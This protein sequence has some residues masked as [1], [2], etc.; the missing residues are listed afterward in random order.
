[1][2]KSNPEL[3]RLAR[4]A[5][6]SL[7][8]WT[9]VVGYSLYSTI[10]TER[11]GAM[12][13]A[14]NAARDNFFKDQAFRLWAS[15]KGG[16]YVVVDERNRPLPYM[17]HVPGRDIQTADGRQL[18]LMNPASMLR[19][20][21][22]QYADLY[23]IK[24]RIVGIKTLN[25]ANKADPWEEKAIHAFERGE[26]EVFEVTDVDGRPHVRLIRPMIMQPPCM[27]CHGHLDFKLGDVRGAV[28]VAVPLENYL[29]SARALEKQSMLTYGGI[30]LVG[31]LGGGMFFRGQRRR[32]QEREASMADLALAA[33]VFDDGMQGIAITDP[34]GVILRV[35]QAFTRITGYA[36]EDAIGQKISLLKSDPRDEAFSAAMRQAILNDGHWSG[37]IWNRHKDGHLYAVSEHS[38]VLRD[39]EGQVRHFI[40]MFEDITQRKHTE[41]ALRE[42]EARWQFALE[43]AGSG[44]WDWNLVTQALYLAP[45]WKAQLGY[46]DHELA[47]EY[48]T[49]EARVHPDD[50]PRVMA[51]IAAYLEGRRP[52]YD[53]EFRMRAKDGKYLWIRARG[54]VTERSEDGA[55]LRMIGVHDDVT[56]R[57]Q[58]EV[59]L[60]NRIIALT[61]PMDASEGIK[62][63]E[64]VNLEEIQHLQDLFA[65]A[66]GV[67]SLITTPA[68]VPITQPSNFSHLCGELIRANSEGTK[69]C[70][71]SDA[72]LGR[73]NPEGPNIQHCLSAG[74]CNA[75]ASIT[76]GGHHVANW[77]IGQ[78]RDESH[79]EQKIIRFA[80]EIGADATQFVEAFRQVPAMAKEQ[81]EK[82]AG[83]LFA[84]ANQISTMAYQNI[85][86]A[87][88]IAERKRAEA[89]LLE[90]DARYRE[91]QRTARL[92]HWSYDV[93]NQNFLWLSE[94]TFR[95][96]GLDPEHGT[97]DY[98]HFIARVHADDQDKVNGIVAHSVASGESFVVTY[99]VPLADGGTRYLEARGEAR[100]GDDGQ[101]GWLNGTVMDISE[102]QLAE[103]G[104]QIFQALAE[105]SFDAIIMARPEDTVLAYANRAA[106]EMFGCD[107]ETREMRGLA[108]TGFW[109]T[110]DHEL[111]GEVMRQ[112]LA[113]G[114]R[115]D[116]RQRRKDGTLFDANATV[117]SIG[118]TQ[119][120]PLQIVALIRDITARKRTEQALRDNE[121]RLSLALSA[122][123][124]G[125]F[126]LDLSSGKAVLSDE[127]AQMLG[128]DPE[129]FE[130]NI[131][132][133]LELL[134][135]E[136]RDQTAAVLAE[137]QSG[138]TT[139]FSI[140]FRMSTAEGDWKWIRSSGQVIDWDAA[141]K[142]RRLVGT[143]LDIEDSKASE[144]ALRIAHGKL[145]AI[146]DFLPDATFVVDVD[147]RVIA[148]NRAIEKM[149]DVSKQEILGKTDRSYAD[150]FYGS[151]RPMLIDL[152]L[153]NRLEEGGRFY[154]S[155]ERNGE[156]LVAEGETPE[157]YRGKGAYIW[158][159]ALPLKDSNGHVIGAIECIRDI[160]ESRRA[161]QALKQSEE[162]LR[163]AL[164]GTSDGIWDWNFVSG[165]T[166]FSPRYYTMLGYQP[167]E[168]PAD[169]EHWRK[170]IHPD[171]LAG[172][173]AAIQAP[174]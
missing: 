79:N 7:A 134:H 165:Q 25:P 53:V 50:L 66:F 169:Y 139:D 104:L 119:G 122:S 74:L 69:R 65:D 125:L 45:G 29:A 90:S 11:D 143:H 60:E 150:A 113:G 153:Q 103:E 173:E 94:E 1:M 131:G 34:E 31:L 85:Q 138:A 133:W 154:Q 86:Q 59:A 43:G 126:D 17:S 14:R 62:F 117:F 83:I 92:G 124:Q 35:N 156:M 28:G 146:I 136:D 116:V 87:R 137:C 3:K 21:M 111:L 172:A 77:L 41:T 127:Y 16:L 102:R 99:R 128:Y 37:E 8:L 91:A 55:P 26:K 80:H 141:S 89:E 4:W 71:H 58:A 95:L 63:D 174:S 170:L 57:K 10:L 24:G 106:H 98:A 164:D 105:A 47:N 64:L 2:R 39:G 33:R 20:M 152:I 82:V 114:W 19:E 108:G 49:F 118:G 120:R 5:F 159:V 67:A 144:E 151:R 12:T 84:V 132:H 129:Y 142:P 101:V 30:W 130:L 52:D 121:A 13:L 145:E 48:A 40:S 168:F 161:E 148:W 88:F 166:Y 140:E 163:H 76:V 115:G 171:D 73:H 135:P 32:I 6:I 44:V 93:A 15:E 51:E 97:P 109:A 100:R 107:Y 56:D 36:P 54:K 38:T 78:V 157:V 155:F 23:G 160:T 42:S 61:R 110:E 96:L 46:Q 112:A 123:R 68:G 167:D 81:F 22:D 27:K 9:A 147:Q 162:R 72:I 158:A 75:G 18:T 149:T 70:E